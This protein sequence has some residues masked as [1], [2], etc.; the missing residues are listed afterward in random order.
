MDDYRVDL[1]IYNGPLDLLLYLIR[2]DE[3]DIQDIP[4]LRITTQ[5]IHYV[6]VLQHVDPESI[7]DFLVMAATLME[8]KSRSLL[9]VPP[10]EEDDGEFVDPRVEL[11]RQLLEYKS[12]K[13]A[14]RAME[15]AAK[16]HA[17]RHPREPVIPPPPEDEVDLDDVEVWD[18]ID[19]F[20][21][22]LE[23]TGKRRTTHAVEFDDTPLLIYIDDALETVERAGGAVKFVEVFEG[24]SRHGMIGLFLA[25]LELI[26]QRRIRATQDEPFGDI[27]LVLLDASPVDDVSQAYAWKADLDRAPAATDAPADSHVESDGIDDGAVADDDDSEDDADDELLGLAAR[28]L[29]RD[30]EPADKSDIA[31]SADRHGANEREEN[32]THDAQ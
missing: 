20:N 10:P 14:A 18:L 26:R 22:L 23:Q 30:D 28:L 9:P 3:I 11:V 27:T 19:A 6:E 29:D 5:F 21:K 32:D 31:E 13:D 15:L 25:L 2:R 7:G 24:R 12:F 17:L 8:I 16:I 1:D 4:I